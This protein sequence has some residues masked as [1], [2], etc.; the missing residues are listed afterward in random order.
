LNNFIIR[1]SVTKE[2]KRGRSRRK[3]G[4]SV[5]ELY[6]MELIGKMGWKQGGIRV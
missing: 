3:S 4:K 6:W 1:K 2:G 5:V